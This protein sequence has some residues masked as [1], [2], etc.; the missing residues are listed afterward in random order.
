MLNN[1]FSQIYEA[2]WKN[3]VEPGRSQMTI[4]AGP[5]TTNNTATTTLQRYI[6]G[7]YCSWA[8]NDGHE[9]ARNML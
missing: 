7:W 8:P 5:T 1:F 6:R 2:M 4:M 3:T 9:D